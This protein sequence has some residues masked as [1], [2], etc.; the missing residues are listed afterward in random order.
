MKHLEGKTVWLRPTGNNVR[1]NN[2]ENITGFIVKVS[3][4]NALVVVGARSTS[5]KFQEQRA[6]P[7]Q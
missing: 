3:R 6:L 1:R 7:E 4:V 5:D 2:R